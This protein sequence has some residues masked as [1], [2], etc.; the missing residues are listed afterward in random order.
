MCCPH[1]QAELAVQMGIVSFP[2]MQA[3]QETLEELPPAEFSLPTDYFNEPLPRKRPKVSSPPSQR[4][5][6]N[7]HPKSVAQLDVSTSKLLHVHASF[8][9]AARAVDG[10]RS[11]IKNICRGEGE[12]GGAY[13]G[14]KWRLAT[15]EEGGTTFATV[16]LDL[17]SGEVICIHESAR[18]AARA[19]DGVGGS[20]AR[21]CSGEA[22]S[23]YG[24]QWRKATPEDAALSK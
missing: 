11:K 9:A 14:F 20:I 6:A 15:H 16:Q 13:C 23:A 12:G 3:L 5:G 10:N 4:K 2:V 18:A 8:A 19:V 21:C 1:C 22:E 24:F 17:S 7:S